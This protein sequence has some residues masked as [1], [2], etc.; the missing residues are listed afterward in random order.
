MTRGGSTFET[1][2]RFRTRLLFPLLIAFSSACSDGKAASQ[3]QPSKLH[4]LSPPTEPAIRLT[5]RVTDAASIIG[6]AQEAALSDQLEQFERATGHQMVVVTVETLEGRDVADFTRD[7]ANAWGIGRQGHHDGVVVLVAPH[8]RKV[9]IAVGYGLEQSLPD[10]VC[11]KIIDEQMLAPF[12]RG[13]FERGI[14]AGVSALIDELTKS[15]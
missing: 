9:R 4:Q 7:L 12:R 3:S 1:S 8:E 5:G 6:T 15:S 2:A 10:S 14:E 13:D 11:Q